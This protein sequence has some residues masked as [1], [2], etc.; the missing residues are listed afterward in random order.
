MVPYARWNRD[1]FDPDVLV[2]RLESL[3]KPDDGSGS[4]VFEG[5]LFFDDVVSVLERATV[6]SEPMP[7]RDQRR[8]VGRALFSAADS[9][10]LTAG[11]LLGEISRGAKEFAERP[12]REFVLATS[13]SVRYFSELA[14][15][16]VSGGN[17]SFGRALP[18][19]L[20]SGHET[21]K[22]RMQHYVFGEYPDSTSLLNH[23]AAAWVLVRGRSEYEA[24]TRALAALDL[25]RG[26]W[27]LALN[28]RRWTR[29][30]AQR[31]KPVNEVLLGPVHSLHN[32]DG[33]LAFEV[34][35]YEYDYV[36]PTQSN[37][38]KRRWEHVKRNEEGVWACLAKSRYRS[39]LEEAIRRY[40]RALDTREWD[41]G[42]VR[43]WGLLEDL[44]GTQPEDNYKVTIRRTAF[45]YAESERDLHVQVLRHLKDYRNRNVHGGEESDDIEAFLYQLKRYVEEVLT[46]HLQSSHK[47]SSIEEAVRFLN[48]PADLAA[49]ERKISDLQRNV[50][51][52]RSEIERARKAREFHSE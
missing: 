43:L 12:E 22:Q 14:N 23:Y 15:T 48:Q 20:R 27:N 50:E 19:R 2:R 29:T 5:D 31:R 42:F 32:P 7:E 46:F 44:T 11:S 49:L 33:T 9:G 13:L 8:I 18:E 47:F 30:T 41:S 52:Q 6:F 37:E 4:V 25:L 17:I 24:A 3:K 36:E 35:W 21:A 1:E 40:T 38:L 45:L 39:E 51:K 34:D 10:P 16:E 26:I 28:R